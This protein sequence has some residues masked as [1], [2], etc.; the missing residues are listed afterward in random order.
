LVPI[1]ISV[2]SAANSII[3]EKQGQYFAFNQIP[4]PKAIYY[5]IMALVEFCRVNTGIKLVRI[6]GVKFDTGV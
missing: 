1:I 2:E 4:L 3:S 6:T 5:Q